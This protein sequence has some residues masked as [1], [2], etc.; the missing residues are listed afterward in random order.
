MNMH[1]IYDYRQEVEW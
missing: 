1:F